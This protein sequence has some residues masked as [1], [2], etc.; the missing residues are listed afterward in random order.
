MIHSMD[1][2]IALRTSDDPDLYQRATHDEAPESVW[3]AI[4]AHHPELR[5]W[6]A[7]NKTV[8][9]HVLQVLA[10]DAD[11]TVRMT[12]ASK[13]KLPAD[14]LAQLAL[15]EEGSVRLAVAQN[16]TTPIPVLEVLASD[17]WSRVAD[18]AAKRLAA[19][20]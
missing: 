19:A 13:R 7:H 5:S 2:F 3:L 15:D 1:E 20:D 14:L 18:V 11:H 17:T 12:V 16:R 6:V 8:P 10:Q 4:I 9:I